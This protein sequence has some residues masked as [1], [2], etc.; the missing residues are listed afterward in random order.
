MGLWGHVCNF[1]YSRMCTCECMRCSC[2]C[3]TMQRH[4]RACECTCVSGYVSCECGCVRE[5]ACKLSCECTRK[6][7]RVFECDFVRV[8]VLES[9]S[10]GECMQ[11]CGHL[12]VCARAIVH[13]CECVRMR[14]CMQHTNNHYLKV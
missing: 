2:K 7:V 10:K 11:A 6:Y 4:V 14:L 13:E 12:S 3:G 1:E 8:Q 9:E 5:S